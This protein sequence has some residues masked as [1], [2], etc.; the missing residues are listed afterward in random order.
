ML[1]FCCYPYIVLPNFVAH[2]T[3]K[4][5]AHTIRCKCKITRFNLAS[6]E[7]R[8]KRF[9]A[10]MRSDGYAKPSETAWL[11]SRDSALSFWNSLECSARKTSWIRFYRLNGVSKKRRTNRNR[12][13]FLWTIS[14]ANTSFFKL[15]SRRKCFVELDRII[16]RKIG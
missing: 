9:L 5:Y 6:R 16:L 14:W 12:L 4:P 10:W 2:L 8:I 13:L 11:T 3:R 15:N 1:E 7:T